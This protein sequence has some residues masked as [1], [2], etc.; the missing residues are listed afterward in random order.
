MPP[1]MKHKLLLILSVLTLLSFSQGFKGGVLAGFVSSQVD[2]DA[3]AGYNKA[4]LQVGAYSK[5]NFNKRWFL[6]NELKYIQ[7]GSNQTFKDDPGLN[8]KIKLSYIEVPFIIGYQ[9]NRKFSVGTGLSYAVLLD[10]EVD[11]NGSLLTKDELNYNNSDVNLLLH[12]K[13]QFN[14]HFWFDT[15]FGY[16]ILPIIDSSPRQFNNLVS[17]SFG[18]EF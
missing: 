10:A 6:L 12:L 17:A 1:F 13:Y 4:G 18:Y 2:G 7:K 16:S 9:L 8:F 14:E 5:F 15:K 3:Y 11:A